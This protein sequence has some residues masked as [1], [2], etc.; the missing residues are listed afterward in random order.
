MIDSITQFTERCFIIMIHVICRSSNIKPS[1]L[2][3]NP[4]SGVA[5]IIHRDVP[6]IGSVAAHPPPLRCR[7]NHRG[8]N[9]SGS[10][11]WRCRVAADKRFQPPSRRGGANESRE[12]Q[13]FLYKKLL[14]LLIKE[15]HIF[16]TKTMRSRGVAGRYSR[17]ASS[18]TFITVMAHRL[19]TANAV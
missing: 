18:S 8:S 16:E 11:E 19:A 4:T 12:K 7:A 2:E 13:N 10:W 14:L 17:Y 9:A 1:C 15:L 6:H 5:S 3:L